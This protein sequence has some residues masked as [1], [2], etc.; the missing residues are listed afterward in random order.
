MTGIRKT[1]F[2][3]LVDAVNRNAGQERVPP[4]A[5]GRRYIL[6]A[7]F[8]PEPIRIAEGRKPALGRDTGTRKDQ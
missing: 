4:K 6:Q 7:V 3:P 1:R 5:I 2:S 8:P